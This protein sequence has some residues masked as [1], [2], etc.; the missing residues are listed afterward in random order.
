MARRTWT[1]E[2]VICA[3][4]DYYR[5]GRLAKVRN[6]DCGLYLAAAKRF[7]TWHKA[8]IAAGITPTRQSWPRERVIAEI[9][10]RHRRGLPLTC[11]RKES[12][13]RG[14]AVRHFGSWHAAVLAAGFEA[15]PRRRWDQQQVL[16]E[17]QDRHVRGRTISSKADVALYAAAK[18]QFGSWHDALVAAG[19]RVGERPKPHIRWSRELIIRELREF[20]R[21]KW[22]VA[23]LTWVN[24]RLC[25]ATKRFFGGRHNAFVAAGLMDG[26]LDK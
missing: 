4:Q 10:D 11:A 12:S 3:I 21:Q 24:S 17:L 23:D 26:V 20:H 19:L 25:S 5:Q 6:E 7:G 2:T 16:Q 15:R 8:L 18:R 22:R 1:N 9:I 14:A 13:L